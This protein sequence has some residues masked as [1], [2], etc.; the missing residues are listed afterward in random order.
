MNNQYNIET[1]FFSLSDLLHININTI[2]DLIYGHIQRSIPCKQMQNIYNI[3]YQN[4]FAWGAN[5]IQ[6]TSNI[7]GIRIL[8][9]SNIDSI[10]S[11]AI[12]FP[13]YPHIIFKTIELEWYGYGYWP[14]FRKNV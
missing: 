3:N 4:M 5:E 10:Q 7:W 11:I 9:H 8:I 14:I 13:S 2:K 12:F 6:A 1:L